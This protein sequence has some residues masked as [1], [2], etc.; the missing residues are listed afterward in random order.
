MKNVLKL[1]VN[2]CPKYVDKNLYKT[3]LVKTESFKKLTPALVELLA[4]CASS[5]TTILLALARPNCPRHRGVNFM[6]LFWPEV[7]DKI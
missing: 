2:F 3:V 6:K 7:M 4:F 1:W 5:W